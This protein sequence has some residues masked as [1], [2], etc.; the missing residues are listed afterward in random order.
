MT[1]VCVCGC[2]AMHSREQAPLPKFACTAKHSLSTCNAARAPA[3][4]FTAWVHGLLLGA[5]PRGHLGREHCKDS[6]RNGDLTNVN[7]A[8]V[9]PITALYCA[10]LY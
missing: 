1:L 4:P 9:S 10:A 5:G 8:A 6:S 3:L 7:V 2:A